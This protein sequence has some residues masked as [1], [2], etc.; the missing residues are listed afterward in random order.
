MRNKKLKQITTRRQADQ[1]AAEHVQQYKDELF[2]KNASE[3]LQQVIAGVLITLEKCYGWKDKRLKDFISNFKMYLE[4][5]QQPDYFNERWNN[6]DNIDY[7]KAEYGIDLRE[8]F[9][10]EVETAAKSR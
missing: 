8:L 1:I 4:T 10:A 6:D 3:I 9:Q 5:M 7:L 2:A